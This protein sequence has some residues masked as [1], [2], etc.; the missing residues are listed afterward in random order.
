M[1]PDVDFDGPSAVEP[2]AAPAVS[3]LIAAFNAEAMLSETLESLVAQTFSE[4]EAIV[5]DDG[6]ND[7]TL[8]L[9]QRFASRDPR[10]RVEHQENAGTASA[11]NRAASLA[12]AEFLVPL[13]A[14]DYLVA[15]A[16]D[17]QLEFVR[18]HRGYHLYAWGQ[19]LLASDGSTRRV[20]SWGGHHRVHEYGLADIAFQRTHVG[21]TLWWQ[22][23]LFEQLGGYHDVYAE[24][25]E[26]A[27]R[28][29]LLGERILYNPEP[30]QVYRV[31]A[32]SKTVARDRQAESVLS[33]LRTA[34]ASCADSDS[35]TARVLDAA[36]RHFTSSQAREEFRQGLATGTS[37]L[38]SLYLRAL[39]R[40]ISL[41]DPWL[42]LAPIALIAP[43]ALKP[44]L[45][46]RR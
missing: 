23:G 19:V 12:R 7:G 8:S 29:A 35:G 13:D 4:W 45:P 5:V 32:S 37:G 14:D 46:P 9:A 17:A 36:A 43:R 1:E 24:D 11:R 41:R 25:F 31:G 40:E 15:S 28:A 26:L 21:A 33:I 18:T 44:L 42:W 27:L 16:L 6:S 34:R 22:R 10:I 39:D 2:A 30:L 38:R 3:V 20:R